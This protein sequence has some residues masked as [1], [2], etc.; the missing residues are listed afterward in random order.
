MLTEQYIFLCADTQRNIKKTSR[1]RDPYWSEQRWR[2]FTEHYIQN[3]VLIC[4][5][6]V[7]L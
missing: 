5:K 2:S 1:I 4:H 6:I 3:V 7:T